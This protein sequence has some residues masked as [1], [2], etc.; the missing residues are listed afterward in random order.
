MA[1][2]DK[3][4]NLAK[5]TFDRYQR[6]INPGMAQLVKF[7][8]FEDVEVRSG[9]CYVYTSDGGR[10]L[11][12]YGGPG[13]F[14]MGH[15]PEPIIARVREQLEAMPLSSHILLDPIA[16]EFAERLADV[17]PAICSTPSSA[18]P[19]PRPWRAH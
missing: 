15:S 9:G 1:D 4:A 18:T 10:L 13:V 16:A 12:C 11:D 3:G 6:Y 2:T 7:M 8:G 5:I 17:T 14:S 19:A